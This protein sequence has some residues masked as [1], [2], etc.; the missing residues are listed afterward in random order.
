MK[1]LF[2]GG[3]GVISS[4]VSALA[5][6]KGIELYLLNRGNRKD[7]VP[8]GAR[9]LIGDIKDADSVR[10]AIKNHRFDSVVDW[11][12]YVP[13]DVEQNIRL[14]SGVTDQFCFI[15]SASA[16]QKPLRHY[17]VD[18]STPLCNPYWEY[19]RDKIACED[20]LMKEYREKGFP[21]T[22]IRP[23]Y[24]YNKTLIPFLF[25]SRK[26]RW[27]L[28]DRMRKGMKIIVPGD[29]TT[30]FAITHNTDFAK[31]FIGLLGNPKAIGHAFH[32]TSDEVLTWDQIAR[33][34]GAAAGAE[35]DI[36]HVSSDFICRVSPE[37]TG[38]LIGEKSWS[39]VYDNSKIKR[40][41]PGFHASMP[42][43]EGIKESISWY[44]ANPGLLSVD[45]DF[46][47]LCD[48]IARGWEKGIEAAML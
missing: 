1:V 5:A 32:I 15:S 44:E 26:H 16:Y 10:A 14:F 4:A 25:N 41:V 23:S 17:L 33:D 24:T 28:I 27:T 22:I 37:H 31:G 46:N 36:L 48:R 30:L 34:I 47:N 43:A 38:G 12:S 7:F 9:V 11:I 29:G 35:P 6:E 3:T 2:V 45:D 8:Q 42:F 20:I 40:F 21:V 18:E 39:I 19:S 13:Q